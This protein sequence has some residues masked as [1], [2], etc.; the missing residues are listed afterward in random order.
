MRSIYVIYDSMSD[1]WNTS[2]RMDIS[3]KKKKKI[4]VQNQLKFGLG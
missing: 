2:Q 4:T 1:N 3:T